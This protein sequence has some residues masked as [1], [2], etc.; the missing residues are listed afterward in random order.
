MLVNLSVTDFVEKTA[1]DAPVPGGG[2]IA[3][4][5]GGIAAGLTEMV[6]NLTIGKKKYED[7]Q[8]EMKTISE[9]V[10]AYKVK[11]VE[12]VDKDAS[13]FD[14]V[15]KAFKMPKETDEEK[16]ARTAAIQKGMK[17][18]A[19]V[20]LDTA[21]TAAGILDWI[22]AVVVRGNSNAV[23]D[24]AVAAMMCRTAVLG[25]LYNVKIN[26]GSIKDEAFVAEVTKEVEE[27]EARA[28]ARE[29]AILDQV[30]L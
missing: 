1:S 7:V 4:L 11:L 19:S 14:D 8:E 26:L 22:E 13:S 16:A 18:A 9:E 17:Y 29:K 3:A 27:L 15:M 25:A 20:P 10:V 12:L 30:K 21:K 5:A 24:G 28:I 6:A 23:T 2:S